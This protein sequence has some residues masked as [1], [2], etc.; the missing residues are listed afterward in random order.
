[1]RRM[2]DL[3]ITHD[4]FSVLSNGQKLDILYEN[5]V[6]M[7]TRLDGINQVKRVQK[8]QWAGFGGLASALG[9]VFYELWKH[10]SGAK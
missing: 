3:N 7:M 9:W 1:M 6:L 10:V 4:Q 5:Q 8:M 2:T